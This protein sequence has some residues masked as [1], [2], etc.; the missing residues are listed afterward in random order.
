MTETQTLHDKG[1]APYHFPKNES[2]KGFTI[3]E[4]L[5]VV[6]IIVVVTATV[7][8]NNAKFGGTILLQ[9]LAF[10]IA[11]STREA[12]IYGLS[13]Q[14]FRSSFTSPFGVHFDINGGNNK[15]YTVFA[16][17]IGVENGHY[18]C[19]NPLD[20]P[21]CELV[22]STTITRGFHISDLCVTPIS[23]TE[24]CNATVLDV[25]YK[26]PEPDAYIR[27]CTTPAQCSTT[28]NQRARV[29]VTSPRGDST[30]ICI[31]INGQISVHSGA[32]CVN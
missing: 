3:I 26:H 10:D 20:K 30:N 27:I 13:V 21:T 8:A 29:V 4:M 6:G 25:V 14:K 9:N 1:P 32:A 31:E 7:L 28:L 5:V 23:G 11:L 18:D 17:A 2:D 19:P 15:T 16:D 22:Q 24:D 12:Q